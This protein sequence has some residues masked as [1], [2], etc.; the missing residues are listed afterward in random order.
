MVAEDR[1]GPVD[2]HC[3]LDLCQ[4]MAAEYARC[5]AARCL[6]LAMTTTPKAYPRNVEMA[7]RG[8]SVNVALGLH[9]QLVAQRASE[10]TLFEEMAPSARY[11]GEVGLDAGRRFYP[12]FDSQKQV[13]ERAMT[14]CERLGEKVISIHSVRASKQVLDIIERTG[15]HRTCTPVLHWFN[16]SASDARRA[17]ELGCFFSVNEQ[18]LLSPRGRALL[19]IAP[20]RRVLT[21]T[22]APFQSSGVGHRLP[23]DTGGAL[24]LIAEAYRSDPE[25]VSGQIRQAASKLLA[26]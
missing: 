22:D 16:A 25:T 9:P 17:L 14:V 12:S 23:G 11:I 8:R 15:V 6:T 13:F 10:M 4:D 21:E 19:E 20:I 18:M 26:I 7:K 5:E 2:F 24:A 1:I 3:H